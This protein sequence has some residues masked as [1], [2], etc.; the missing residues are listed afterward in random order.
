M[1]PVPASPI[2]FS[3]LLLTGAAGGLG[4]ELRPRLKAHCD[5]LRVS[6]VA[7]LGD[8]AMGEEV[9]PARLEDKATVYALLQD[10]SAVVHLGGVSTEQPFEPILAA[11]I[12][13]VYHLYE[14]ARLQRVKRIVF[15]SSNHVTGFY[16]QD[17][18]LGTDAAP[19]PDGLYGVSKAFGENLSRFYWD[20]HRIE[21]VC[22][23]IGSS[24]PEP[25]D[26]RMLATWLSFDDLER[27]VLAALTAPVVGHS[28]IYGMSDNAVTW[29]DNTGARHIGYRPQD[30]SDRF[31]AAVEARQ[32]TLDLNDPAVIYQGGAFV[33]TGPFE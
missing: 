32:P 33:R 11:N 26:R 31:R 23:R 22:L 3:R 1:P 8:A 10:V 27:L 20:R 17:E 12:V 30:S 24:F 18:V 15:A 29:W 6:D 5:T 28:V 21:T 16:R 4:R 14:A 13:G 9:V 7:E 2:R 25:K 19:R